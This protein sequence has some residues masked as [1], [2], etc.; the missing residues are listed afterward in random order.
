[1]LLFFVLRS[2]LD[3][4]LITV[5]IWSIATFLFV[6]S[7]AT[8]YFV[9]ELGAETQLDFKNERY[10]ALYIATLL[11]NHCTKLTPVLKPNLKLNHA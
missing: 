8:M 4:F 7:D 6:I 1:L 11:S 5:K 10:I 3:Q 2:L 9:C